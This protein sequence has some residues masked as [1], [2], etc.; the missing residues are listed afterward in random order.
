[1]RLIVLFFGKLA[2]RAGLR[3]IGYDIPDTGLR[4]YALRD[5]V[6]S[7]AFAL[8]GLSPSEVRM[9]VNQVLCVDDRP[10][11]DGDEVAFFSPF[12]GG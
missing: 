6:L 10:L 5:D 12:S 4:L 3:Q 9:S 7:E 11:S 8:G 2:D 1:M